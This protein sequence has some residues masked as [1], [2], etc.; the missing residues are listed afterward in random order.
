MVGRGLLVSVGLI[1]IC[2]TLGAG[3][4]QAA[5]SVT[6]PKHNVGRESRG[7]ELAQSCQGTTCIT[8]SGRRYPCRSLRN[9]KW[10]CSHCCIA[11]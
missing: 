11:R 5:Y 6:A 3:T 2:F 1:A 10:Y 9:G 7:I 4:P 8:K